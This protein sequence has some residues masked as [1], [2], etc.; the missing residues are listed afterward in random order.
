MF[1]CILREEGEAPLEVFASDLPE[2]RARRSGEESDGDGDA[3]PSWNDE[4]AADPHAEVHEEEEAGPTAE[5]VT[6]S[7]TDD[8]VGGSGSS[9]SGSRWPAA[10][11]P[12]AKR[13]RSSTLPPSSLGRKKGPPPVVSGS[14]PPPFAFIIF[15][16]FL[17]L[18]FCP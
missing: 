9:R 14:V 7:A 6:R 11:E 12:V 13:S 17:F 2:P 3:F 8:E 5:P 10:E 15:C 1:S 4:S 16:L 18:P